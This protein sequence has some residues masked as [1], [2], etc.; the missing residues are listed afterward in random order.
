MRRRRR[1]AGPPGERVVAW[2]QSRQPSRD[3]TE[4]V[5]VAEA[6]QRD[7]DRFVPISIGLGEAEQ[8]RVL[9]RDRLHLAERSGPLRLGDG[10]P[11]AECTNELTGGRS[12]AIV[13]HAPTRTGAARRARR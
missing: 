4:L 9:R 11:I 12:Q 1:R 2:M 5:G 3:L 8:P 10:S 13:A 7:L 6:I